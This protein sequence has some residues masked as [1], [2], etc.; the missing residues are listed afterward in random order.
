MVGVLGMMLW[1]SPLLTGVAV[2]V[3][4][5]SITA[6][7]LIGRRAQPRFT[8]QARSAGLLTAQIEE[9]YAGHELAKVYDQRQETIDRLREHNE[10][11]HQVGRRAQF[12]SSTI[13]P[14]LNFL[15]NIGH[16]LVAIVGGL[17]VASGTM[18]IGEAQAFVQYSRQFGGPLANA[19]SLSSVVQ[20]A[21]ASAARVFELLDADEEPAE[22]PAPHRVA[23]RQALL[24]ARL[25][26]LRS[27]PASAQGR[28]VQ[29]GKGAYVGVGGAHR[30]SKT[31][32]V[33]LLLRF[34]DAT[35]GHIY[36]DGHDITKMPRSQLRSAMGMVL[37]DTWLLR[38]PSPTTSPTESTERRARR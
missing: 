24:R 19:A 6:T 7:A 29:R 33:N 16:V 28:V 3:V 14:S 30:A 20:S 9:A 5:L 22:E 1:L 2:V 12:L 35:S 4:L 13:Q 27:T 17:R 21:I 32:L 8:R 25:V 10:E 36:L 34:Y 15:T 23:A 18:S 38:R 26:Q 11:L 37:Q 31:T